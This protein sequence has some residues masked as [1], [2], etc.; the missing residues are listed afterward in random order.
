MRKLFGILA[1]CVLTSAVSGQN[2]CTIS[3]IVKDARTQEALFYAQ[4][5]LLKAA[6]SSS[7][8]GSF[9]NE[10][11]SFEITDVLPG[12]YI[13][14]ASY[15]GY[16]VYR[17]E[18]VVTKDN[19]TMNMDTILLHPQ[20]TTLEGVTV[21]GQKPVYTIDGEK[22]IYNVS[23]DGGIQTGTASDALQNAPGVEVD[24]E[25]NITLRGVSSVEIW[26]ND[27]PSKLNA[28]NL[29]TYIQQLPANSLE[30]IEVIA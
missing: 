20:S 8:G 6:D 11:G 2:K 9:T 17:K 5:G 24:I 28:E 19:R 29:K 25:G 7:A 21:Y 13:L 4:T 3:G 23:E 18:I 10:L 22:T 14:Q 30:R 26:I 16:E 27:R 15:V 12:T 1:L